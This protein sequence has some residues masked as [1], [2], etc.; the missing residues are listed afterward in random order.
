MLSALVHFPEL[1]LC[2]G[3]QVSLKFE[4]GRLTVGRNVTLTLA[5]IS[6]RGCDDSRVI[7]QQN[8]T[9]QHCVLS[10]TKHYKYRLC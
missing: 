8:A 10:I 5:L 7:V 1:V 3:V 2:L 6:V 9:E 4:T